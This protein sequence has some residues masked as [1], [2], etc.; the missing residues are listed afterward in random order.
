MDVKLINEYRF[1]AK[2]TDNN[3]RFVLHFGSIIPQSYTELPASIYFDGHEM[4]IDLTMVDQNAS[5]QLVDLSGRIL[6]KRD[7]NGRTINKIHVPSSSQLLLVYVSTTNA[8]VCR[9]I[10]MNQF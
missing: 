7:I 1:S 8:S 2:T 5:V 4:V 10:F 6:L 9:K 3:D